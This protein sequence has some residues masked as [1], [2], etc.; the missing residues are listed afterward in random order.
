MR[1]QICR[2]QSARAKNYVDNWDEMKEIIRCVLGTG[3]PGKV[4]CRMHAMN[5]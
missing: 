3:G 4:C 5:F 2:M 1:T